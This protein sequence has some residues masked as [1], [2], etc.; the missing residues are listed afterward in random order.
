MKNRRKKEMKV[1]TQERIHVMIF[2][3]RNVVTYPSVVVYMWLP[4]D[5][6]F[7]INETSLPHNWQE[8]SSWR[9]C[10]LRSATSATAV[11]EFIIFFF[12]CIFFLFLEPQQQQEN[13]KEGGRERERLRECSPP[14]SCRCL[15]VEK[16]SY[17][18]HTP[19]FECARPAIP[20][21]TLSPMA[22]RTVK[23]MEIPFVLRPFSHTDR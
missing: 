5:F 18:A 16:K 1:H 6:M 14:H 9:P 19:S 21:P 20:F 4:F 13:D 2:N 12:C 11:S 15:L 7:N 8:R 3:S 23:M 10:H 17:T 22:S